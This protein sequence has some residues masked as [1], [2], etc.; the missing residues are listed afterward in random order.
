MDDIL[1]PEQPDISVRSG[2]AVPGFFQ[3]KRGGVEHDR[4]THYTAAVD[5]DGGLRAWCDV[6]FDPERVEPT[7]QPNKPPEP[8]EIE[9]TRPCI[10]CQLR[11]ME[12]KDRENESRELPVRI[13]AADRLIMWL[14]TRSRWSIESAIQG[15][16]ER[17]FTKSELEDTAALFDQLMRILRERAANIDSP[18]SSAVSDG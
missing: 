9:S 16:G 11:R 18:T 2:S 6:A 17:T 12:A 8:G 5:D 3:I 14:L 15:I 10:L 7:S 13:P 1:R 4:V